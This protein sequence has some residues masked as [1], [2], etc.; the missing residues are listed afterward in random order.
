MKQTT[1]NSKNN[2]YIQNTRI[3][4]TMGLQD[5]LKVTKKQTTIDSANNGYMSGGFNKLTLGHED[6]K[7][8]VKESTLDGYTGVAGSQGYS[9]NMLKDNFANAETNPNKEIISQGRMPGLS[10]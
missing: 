6:Q 3:N 2:G 1:I 7:V 10:I 5:K 8:T 9:G 4:E